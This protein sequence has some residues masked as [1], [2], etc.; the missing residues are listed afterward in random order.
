MFQ[1]RFG[2]RWIPTR[3]ASLTALTTAS[4]ILLWVILIYIDRK[5]GTED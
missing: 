5:Y 4:I 3:G 2:A 1:L